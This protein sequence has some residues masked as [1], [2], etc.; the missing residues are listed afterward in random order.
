MTRSGSCAY[1]CMLIHPQHALGG[2]NIDQEDF[3]SIWNA[4]RIALRE[5]H[6]RNAS[7]ISFEQLYRLAYKIV[8]QKNGDKLYEK[9]KEFEEQ[10][11]AAEVMPQIRALITKN[12]TGLTMSGGSNS[13]ANERRITGEKFLKG[14]KSSWEDHILCMN[15]IGD[16]L[17]YM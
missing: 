1:L 8:L 9:V 14:I 17:M 5:I 16:V 11:F 2:K 4:I 13:T 3:E 12:H 15:M 10:W 6:T 7:Q